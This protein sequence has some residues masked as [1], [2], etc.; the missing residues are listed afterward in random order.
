[1]CGYKFDKFY[2]RE[3]GEWML[4]NAVLSNGMAY[5]P[6]CLEDADKGENVSVLCGNSSSSSRWP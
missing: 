1:M 6:I 3:E 5:H 2:D 4:E